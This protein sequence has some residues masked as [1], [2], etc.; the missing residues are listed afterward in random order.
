M[1]RGLR[2]G[3]LAIASGAVAFAVV[4]A[5]L[6]LRLTSPQPRPVGPPGDYLPDGT[7]AVGFLAADGVGLRGWYSVAPAAPDGSPAQAVALL[8]GFGGNR[9]QML[10]RAGWFRRR[11]CTVLLY[12][13]RGHGES[14]GDRISAGWFETRDLHGAVDFLRRRGHR[15]IGLVGASQ[16]A[17][18]IALAASELRDIRWVVLE[19]MYPTLRDALDRRF[20]LALGPAGPVAGSLLVFFAQLRLGIDL[21]N[22]DPLARGAILTCPVLVAHGEADRHT[23]AASAEAFYARL[24]GPKAIWIVSGAGHVDLYGFAPRD[25]EARVDRFLSSLH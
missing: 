14:G 6:A 3:L 4:S 15:D 22:V 24:P 18:T 10:A 11:G 23:A 25:Y 20:R 5:F 9:R 13:A 16:G 2:L 21:D 19:S 8:H 1:R 17:A 12:D 7:E